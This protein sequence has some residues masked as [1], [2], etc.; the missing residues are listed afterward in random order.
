M[1]KSNLNITKRYD[2]LDAYRLFASIGVI[3]IHCRYQLFHTQWFQAIQF[4]LAM[5]VPFFFMI[6]G[7]FLTDKADKIKKQLRKLFGIYLY[8]LI[9]YV[10]IDYVR[11]GINYFSFFSLKDILYILFMNHTP[12]NGVLWFIPASIMLLIC[13]KYIFSRISDIYNRII[14]FISLIISL[15]LITCKYKGIIDIPITNFYMQGISFYLLG[16][17]LSKLGVSNLRKVI[18]IS[19]VATIVISIFSIIENSFND[20]R[21]IIGT[22]T[23]TIIFISGL[24]FKKNNAIIAVMGILGRKYSLGIYI[25]HIISIWLTPG[26]LKRIGHEEIFSIY[27]VIS[28]LITSLILTFISNKISKRIIAKN[29]NRPK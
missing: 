15:T 3:T 21:F 28:V 12:W 2:L 13:D 22:V 19:S 8:T 23:L 29:I 9:L 5:C 24:L 26:F 10:F 27:P 4:L 20:N 7:Y 11:Y 6:S 1:N 25:Y 17:Q 18:V 14:F 16:R